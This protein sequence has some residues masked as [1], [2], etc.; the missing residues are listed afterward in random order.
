MDYSKLKVTELKELLQSRNLPVS[1]KK[2]ELIARLHENDISKHPTSTDDLGD[3][4]PPEEE[5]DWDTPA[6][7]TSTTALCR[8]D[9]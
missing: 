5:Y 3:L 6:N 1:G 7:Q 8:T 9:A 2:E 4:A